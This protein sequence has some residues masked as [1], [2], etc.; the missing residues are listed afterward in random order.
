MELN[1]TQ[2]KALE[3]SKKLKDAFG[4][5]VAYTEVY[6]VVDVANHYSFK[7]RFLA[8]S[9]FWVVFQ[10]DLDLIGCYIEGGNNRCI[11]LSNDEMRGYSSTDLDKYFEQVREELELRIPDK[12]L[13]ANG[14]L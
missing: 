9:Y 6:D 14:W 11:F 4:N 1:D 2:K 5:R 12:Y 7:I 8:Y 3:V 13:K 10:Y